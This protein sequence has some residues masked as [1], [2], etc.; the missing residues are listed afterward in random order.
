MLKHLSFLLLFELITISIL[1]D[2]I[3]STDA[4]KEAVTLNWREIFFF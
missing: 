2:V 3:N 4:K 1:F